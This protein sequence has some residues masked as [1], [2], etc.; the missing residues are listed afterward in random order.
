MFV[1]A[2]WAALKDGA[3]TP[4]G[5]L[6]KALGLDDETLLRVVNFLDRWKFIDV[7]RSPEL[8]IRRKVGTIS[9]V[10][11]FELLRGI[12]RK[13]LE[14]EPHVGQRRLAERVACRTCQ[15][16]SFTFVGRNEVECLVCHERQWYAIEAAEPS[17]G[18]GG[19][20]EM[21]A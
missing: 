21:L 8:R 15:G 2:V 12:I 11:V 13:D 16:Q 20:E 3:W 5:T 4:T 1:E 17:M 19:F 6:K 7:H 18:H 9:P 10:T 14:C